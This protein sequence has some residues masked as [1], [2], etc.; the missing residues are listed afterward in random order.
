MNLNPIYSLESKQIKPHKFQHKH[1]LVWVKIWFCFNTLITYHCYNNTRLEEQT[2][3]TSYEKRAAK[4]KI[5]SRKTEEEI[6]G[7]GESGVEK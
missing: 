6:K 5:V 4:K 1:G 7:V 3:T 2:K